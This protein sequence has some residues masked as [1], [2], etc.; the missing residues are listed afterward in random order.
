M[1]YIILVRVI[2]LLF[3][4]YQVVVGIT[5][6]LDTRGS[7]STH[8]HRN[9]G[10]WNIHWEKSP[11]TNPHFLKNL[12]ETSLSSSI[13]T[14][15]T[16]PS[17]RT[18][19]ITLLS[20]KLP[21][22]LFLWASLVFNIPADPSLKNKNVLITKRRKWDSF[23]L[24]INIQARGSGSPSPSSL[25]RPKARLSRMRTLIIWRV[26]GLVNFQVSHSRVTW[27]ASSWLNLTLSGLD[28]VSKASGRLRRGQQW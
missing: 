10:L 13:W 21:S 5:S 1:I 14:Q 24:Y 8:I 11:C 28:T 6:W 27:L 4:T 2:S 17:S 12:F 23:H 7:N 22:P 19:S 18:I 15:G 16:S 25:K 3:I 9:Q 20:R 26:S